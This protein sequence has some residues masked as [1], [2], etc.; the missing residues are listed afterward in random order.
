MYQVVETSYEDK[1]KMYQSVDK[2]KLIEMLIECNRIIAA[3]PI[4][5]TYTEGD[6]EIFTT[7]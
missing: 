6:Q 2:D 5:A 4:R 1:V 3:R 7:N